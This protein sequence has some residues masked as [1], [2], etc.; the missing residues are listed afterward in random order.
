MRRLLIA[1]L[2]VLWSGTLVVPAESRPDGLADKC[3]WSQVMEAF[4]NAP[5]DQR[6]KL[7]ARPNKQ[8]SVASPSGHFRVHYDTTGTHAVYQPTVDLDPADGIPDYVNRCTEIADF[9][10]ATEVDGMGYLAP[11]FDGAAGGDERYDIY[12]HHYSGAYGVTFPE[13]ASSQYPG[14]NSITSYVFVDPTYQGFGYSDRTLPLK[15]TTAHE[16]MHAIQMTYNGYMSAWWWGE[17]QAVWMEDVVYDEID[18]YRQ[19]L[20][21]FFSEPYRKLT[22]QNG[23]FEYGACVWPTY[24]AHQFG[25]DIMR[26]ILDTAAQTAMIY[27]LDDVLVLHGSS[28]AQEFQTFTAWNYFTGGRDDGQHY[29]EGAAF[30][31]VSIEAAHS[32]FPL[33]DAGTCHAPEA[34]AC[35]YVQF[36][37]PEQTQ[38]NLLVAFRGGVGKPWG[39]SVIERMEQSQSNTYQAT[40]DEDREALFE[41][42]DFGTMNQV[43]MI[44][45]TLASGGQATPYSYSAALGPAVIRV[46]SFDLHEEQGDGDGRPEMGELL[47]LLVSLE[48]CFADMDSA[49]AV[50]RSSAP[51]IALLDTVSFVGDLLYGDTVCCETAFR[52]QVGDFDSA[53]FADFDVALTSLSTGLEGLAGLRT[54]VGLPP[55]LV[56]DDDGGSAYEAYYGDALDELGMVYDMWD[57]VEGAFLFAPQ[58]DLQ[59]GIFDAVVL[60]TGDAVGGGTLDD[61]EVAL[62]EAYLDEEGALLLSGQNLAEDLSAGSGAQQ[63]FLENYLHCSYSG[64]WAQHIVNGRDGDPVGSGLTL[65]TT[66]TEG[67]QNQTSQDALVPL[68]CA[69]EGFQ[70]GTEGPAAGIHSRNGYRLVLLGFGIEG[71]S[72]HSTS[73]NTRSDVLG[74]ALTWMLHP[75]LVAETELP[76]PGMRLLH[77]SPNPF[78]DRTV[79]RLVGPVG[80]GARL[81]V[82]DVLGRR[83]TTLNSQTT[84]EGSVFTWDGRDRSGRRLSP[85]VYTLRL[86]GTARRTAL[87][88]TLIR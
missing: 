9:C 11:P 66:G 21:A 35:N 81:V 80:D 26:E 57:E 13:N 59:L 64:S 65:A 17:Q 79:L 76:R 70:Y 77:P 46:A 23:W 51:C 86:Q 88:V 14:Y 73:F 32:E 2:S 6:T 56:Y 10:W 4:L 67:A 63:S 52:F 25:N 74:R 7:Y 3:G 54:V 19:Y 28:L 49:Q 27:A 8:A 53:C 71:M 33:L 37:P 45:A 78:A 12:M 38:E 20:S 61:Q 34:L 75:E 5:P 39:V 22:T 29:E 84:G 43:V 44:P 40:V 15:V 36:Y 58:A 55:V 47:S 82:F 60:Y 42:P 69:I 1:V 83:V 24:L 16:F 68:G 50:L 62:L 85:G 18:D 30:P 48:N 87:R 72:E 31:L 41:I